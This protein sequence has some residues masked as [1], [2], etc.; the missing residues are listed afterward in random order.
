MY[1][2]QRQL[3]VDGPW[4]GRLAGLSRRIRLLWLVSL[5]ATALLALYPKA[6]LLSGE[7][8]AVRND[9][10]AHILNWAWLALLPFGF[11]RR[12]IRAATRSLLAVPFGIV[13]EILQYY[14]PGRSFEL[15]D[16]ASDALGTALGF[17]CG[18]ILSRLRRA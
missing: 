15:S 7:M 8:L 11:E 12:R 9:H 16:I 10:W 14:V 3:Q 1:P 6:N 13:L 4:G 2:E 18:L 17:A 5:A